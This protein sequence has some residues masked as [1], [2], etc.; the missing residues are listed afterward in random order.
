MATLKKIKR[1]GGEAYQINFVHPVTEKRVRKTLWCSH[2]DA[3]KIKKKIEADIALGIFSIDPKYDIDFRWSVLK[4]RY[5]SYVKRSSALKT[6][7]RIK[8]VLNA[9]D[10]YIE[11]TDPLLTDITQQTIE[12]FKLHRLELG[13]KND[14]VALELRHLKATFN[15]GIVWKLNNNNPVIGVKHPKKEINNVRYLTLTEIKSLLEAIDKAGEREFKRAVLVY[16][17]TGARR[18][19]I[20]KPNLTWDDV[21]FDNKQI[22]LR[23]KGDKKRY[24]P[25]NKVLMDLFQEIK[26]EGCEYPFEYCPDY[27][28][29]R[30]AVYYEA[31][32]IQGA[33]LHSLRKTFGSVLIQNN[34]AD[35]YTVSKLLG[36]S[37]IRVT[38]KYYVDLLESNLRDSVT[39]LES[40]I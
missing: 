8:N 22:L 34:I 39:G 17:H 36:H 29:H 16:L 38:E 3:V 1:K 21:D 37:S 28:T 40:L 25:L 11:N 7:R 26:S 2:K 12:N 33:T 19:E 32:K 23:G 4:E 18:F 31:A 9:F 30:I 20:L 24:V 5:L 10:N 27:Y 35:I 6:Y 15:Q 13:R 14:T